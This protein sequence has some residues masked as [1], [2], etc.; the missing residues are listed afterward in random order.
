MRLSIEPNI[1]TLTR[2]LRQFKYKS[3]FTS[4]AETEDGV[5]E[6]G[7]IRTFAGHDILYRLGTVFCAQKYICIYTHS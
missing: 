1:F 3:K 4:Q 2:T 6:Y 7:T 5:T